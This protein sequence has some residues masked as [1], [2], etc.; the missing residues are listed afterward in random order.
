MSARVTVTMG[1]TG[2]IAVKRATTP[3]QIAELSGEAERLREASHPGV[4]SLVEHRMVDGQAELRTA[5]AGQALNRWHG[6][7]DQ[8]AALAAAVAA[9]LADLHEIGVVHGRLDSSHV[10]VAADGRPRLCGLSPTV[11][12]VEPADD[13]AAVGRLLEDLV[14]KAGPRSGGNLWRPRL[15]L[16]QRRALLQLVARAT[17]PRAGRRPSARS[18]A[19]SIL[20]AAP[21]AELGPGDPVPLPELTRPNRT[22]V[23]EAADDL[24][25]DQTTA[26]FED[27]F[28]DRPWPT[29]PAS[30]HATSAHRRGQ[31]APKRR[32]VG[33]LTWAA[34]VVTAI[35]AAG[36]WL[37]DNPPGRG[38]ADS[39][40]AADEGSGR[41]TPTA[42]CQRAEPP[43][44]DVDGDGCPETVD[45][46][47]GVVEVGGHR[48]AVGEPGDVITVGDWNCDGVATPAVYR[49]ATGD[50]FVFRGWARPDQPLAAQPLTRVDG[51]QSLTTVRAGDGT[52]DERACDAP[53]VELATGGRHLVEV[54]P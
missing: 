18:L 39:R 45:V 26:E 40:A 8:A 38:G 33:V 49:P 27:L 35:V 22:G 16:S 25:G 46:A 50:V 13:V 21:E 41:P 48:W 14:E 44:A 15:Q 36:L 32:P 20:A 5:F 4:V 30:P 7:L 29:E 43:M 12:E 31:R 34:L 19:R 37:A 53:A 28:L 2:A 11:A 42:P 3:D 52:E 9:T 54:G 6:S 47:D 24:F 23:A 17:D 51:G 10:L 1:D